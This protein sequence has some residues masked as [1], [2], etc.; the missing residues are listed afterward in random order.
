MR[1]GGN[2]EGRNVLR[3]DEARSTRRRRPRWRR[4]APNCSRCARARPRPGLDDKILVDWN[5][6][7]IAALARAAAVFDAPEMLAAARAAFDFLDAKLR[8]AQGRLVHAW[9][10]GRIGAAGMLDDCASFARAALALFEATGEPRYLEPR[11]AARRAPRC[12]ASAR[13][14]AAFISP[15]PTPRTRPPCAPRLAN[16]G[17]TPSGV[18]LMAEVLVRLYHLTDA[19]EWREAAERLIARLRRR[20]SARPHAI[21]AAARRPGISSRAAAASRSRATPPT[22]AAAL[23]AA[24]RRAADPALAVLPLDRA[25]GRRA[26]PAAAR[27]RRRPPAAMLCRGQVCGLPERDPEALAAALRRL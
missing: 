16:D 14:T 26:R 7:M 18:G 27:R 22:R 2:W 17:A 3:H 11:R 4:R 19:G 6:L 12:A 9:R 8:D 15:R 10:E 24:A 23:V 25:L 20:R 21:A 1:E 13:P 5:G